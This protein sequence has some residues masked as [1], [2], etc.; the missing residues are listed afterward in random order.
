MAAERSPFNHPRRQEIP[1]QDLSR[2]PDQSPEFDGERRHRSS[3][4]RNILGNRRSFTGRVNTAYERVDEGSPPAR[5][6]HH[7]VPHITTPRNAHQP[8]PYDDGEVSPV[9]VGGFATAM[10]SVGLNFEPSFE[11]PSEPAGPSRPTLGRRR[12]TLNPIN[13]TDDLPTFSM[14]PTPMLNEPD[15]DNYFSPQDNDQTPLTDARYLAPISGA[16]QSAAHSRMGSRL[17]DDLNMEAGRAARPSS[18]LSSKSL[19]PPMAGSTLSRAG[20]MI[21]KASQ[22]VVNLSNEPDAIDSHM[23]RRRSTSHGEGRMEAPPALPAMPDYAHDDTSSLSVPVEKT[24]PV[25]TSTEDLESQLSH[26][27]PLR[28]KSLGIFGPENR[29]RLL[30]REVLVHPATEPILLILIVIQTIVLAIDSATPV[31][32]L[33]KPMDWKV[34]WANYVLLGLFSIYTLEIAVRV[35]VSG[36]V[37]N[38]EEYSTNDLHLP[39]VVAIRNRIQS[40]FTPQRRPSTTNTTNAA[41]PEPSILRSFT[42]G[43]VHVDQP[44]HSRQAQRLRLARRAFLRH[45]FN[46]LDFVA[47]ISYWIYFF[48]SVFWIA[49]NHH[50]Y[51][52]KM[53]S[54]LRILRLLGLT[55]GTSVCACT[56]PLICTHADFLTGYF[57]KSKESC[58]IAS[59]C[60]VFDWVLLAFIRHHW[61]PVF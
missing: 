29:L 21:R 3:R 49:P 50:I 11:P 5:Q 31:L 44:G 17:G 51:V 55:S 13:E 6:G 9:D 10:G 2:S 37:K 32:Y 54:C 18:T 58:S 46:R 47:V 16:P 8:Y 20:T 45:S 12:S 52:F 23:R 28:G 34:S 43:P 40:F 7:G 1:L 25:V 4:S 19:A 36:F 56:A 14:T 33:Q 59:Q 39:V 27:N 41:V 61:S 53:L 60:C 57:A 24:R 48:L 15:P 26:P 35:I 42:N 38:A 22:R 30:L